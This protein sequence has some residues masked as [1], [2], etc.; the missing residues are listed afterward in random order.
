MNASELAA[1]IQ[2]EIFLARLTSIW[3]KLPPEVHAS[4]IILAEKA[5]FQPS[6]ATV[7]VE[8]EDNNPWTRYARAIAIFRAGISDAWF[9]A[10][11]KRLA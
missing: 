2:Q 9:L 1:D 3:S 8:G 5:I 7:H 6:S 10:A 11:I 4:L